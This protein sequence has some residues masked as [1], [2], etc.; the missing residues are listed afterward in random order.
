MIQL[1][2]PEVFDW[3]AGAVPTGVKLERGSNGR[4]SGP[5]ALPIA[6]GFDELLSPK[7]VRRR[8]A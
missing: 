3:S 8:G 1:Q 6:S 2:R 5:S 4:E 7:Q